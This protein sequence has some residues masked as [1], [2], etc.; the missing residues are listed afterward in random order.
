MKNSFKKII[1]ILLCMVMVVSIVA[2]PACNSQGGDETEKSSE[3]PTESGE[4]I[5]VVVF[6]ADAAKGSVISAKD[7]EIVEMSESLLPEKYFEKRT[8]AIGRTLNAD[9]KAGDCVHEGILVPDES[10][11]NGIS[12]DEINAIKEELRDKF[13]EELRKEILAE[14][15]SDM[16]SGGINGAD[17]GYV[18]LTD[19][20]AANT[21]KDV[22]AEIQKVI[23][24]NPTKTIYVPDGVYVLASPIVTSA[25]PAK[26][27]S[28]QLSNFAV[29]QAATGWEHEEAMIRIG[30]KDTNANADVDSGNYSFNSGII[31]GNGVAKGIAIESGTNF[32]IRN[33]SIKH[34]SIGIHVKE[35]ASATDI[36][37]VH[38]VCNN[39]KNSIGVLLEGP[40]NTVTD[41]RIASMQ[42]GIML[43]STGNFLRNLHPLYIWGSEHVADTNIVYAE[44]V[45]F[46][47]Q[48]NGVN[49]YDFCYSDEMSTGFRFG[50][51]ARPVTQSCFVM[52]YSKRGNRQIG[53]E[54]DSKFE[55]TVLDI[56]VSLHGDLPADAIVEFLRVGEEG[57]QGIIQ[58]PKFTASYTRNDC[59]KDYLVGRVAS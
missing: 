25:D 4:K 21:G 49:F 28:F 56:V 3:T 47:D 20:V 45:A 2:M 41:M 32:A 55:G 59:Y 19:Y 34:T 13:K 18:V 27:V 17:L 24:D 39:K 37:L 43:K 54:A 51:N 35:T 31:D 36:D 7:V 9:V 29:F 11:E 33:S 46:F 22:S 53:I 26:S 30:A 12:K 40:D 42:T 14:L 44:S 5:S 58:N 6:S 48:S 57:G 15:K 16:E 1:S 50:E 8:D 23:D 38:V 52:W 10:K